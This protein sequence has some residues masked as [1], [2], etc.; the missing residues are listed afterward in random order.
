MDQIFNQPTF[1]NLFIAR[2][3]C[4]FFLEKDYAPCGFILSHF[5]NENI[6]GIVIARTRMSTFSLNKLN[7]SILI[8][9]VRAKRTRS[10][11]Q[12]CVHV[13]YV[14]MRVRVRVRVRVRACVCVC[15]C[16][17]LVC[18]IFPTCNVL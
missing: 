16:V 15:V 11:A 12:V 7:N 10:L 5:C 18:T 8:T 13:W 1:L 3:Y 2:I 9:I 14:R 4:P 17:V 6:V